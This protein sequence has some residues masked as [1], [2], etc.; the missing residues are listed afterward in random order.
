MRMAFCGMLYL[1]IPFGIYDDETPV[2]FCMV[3]FGADDDWEDAP[4]IAKNNYNLWRFMIDE[5]HQGKGYGKA[6]MKQIMDYIASEPCGSAE[7]CW[8]SYEPENAAAKTLYASFGFME[9]GEW[10]GNETIAVLKL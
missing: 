2:G 10:D 7:Y 3:G 6:A 1:G 8:L 4:A 5:R 9:T